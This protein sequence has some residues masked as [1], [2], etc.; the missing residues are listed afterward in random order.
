MLGQTKVLVALRVR[1]SVAGT[2]YFV[3]FLTG[4]VYFLCMCVAIDS[5][6]CEN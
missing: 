1:H 5:T 6:L 2:W 4:H 3:N